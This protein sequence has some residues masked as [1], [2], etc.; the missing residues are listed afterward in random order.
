MRGG[1]TLEHKVLEG[2]G[3]PKFVN[4]VRGRIKVEVG[5]EGGMGGAKVRRDDLEAP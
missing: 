5:M 3:G 2:E 1:E 4:S